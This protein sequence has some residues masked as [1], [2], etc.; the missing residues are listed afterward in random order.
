MW[1]RTRGHQQQLP[2]AG[3]QGTASAASG[4][5]HVL[6]LAA[7]AVANF[8]LL[9]ASARVLV[10]SGATR[11]LVTLARTC[12]K[13]GSPLG[14]GG[15]QGVLSCTAAAL[16][17][18]AFHEFGRPALVADGAV[19]PLVSICSSAAHA[20]AASSS[21]AQKTQYDDETSSGGGKVM[22][23]PIVVAYS[24]AALR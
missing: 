23:D 9:P 7:G 22:F 16:A 11:G 17:N 3:P 19:S 5:E 18:L 15:G 12:M 10:R 1:P 14:K 8:A 4:E 21:E 24:A 20:A 6:A 13:M 2:T